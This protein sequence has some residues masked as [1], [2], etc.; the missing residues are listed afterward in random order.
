MKL[1]PF[2]F[3]VD[4]AVRAVMKISEVLLEY[5]NFRISIFFSTWEVLLFLCLPFER[6]SLGDVLRDAIQEEVTLR[7]PDSFS[8]GSFPS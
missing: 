1:V 7:F 8:G 4:W 6:P 2:C 5:P 3:R